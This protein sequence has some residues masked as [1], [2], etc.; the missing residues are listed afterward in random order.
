ME[1][2]VQWKDE[3][4]LE[5]SE[6]YDCCH[7]EALFRKEG[8]EWKLETHGAF[9]TDVWYTCLVKSYPDLDLRVFSQKALQAQNPCE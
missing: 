6:D 2:S 7:V 9:A 3:R 5:I 8:G 4:K 1:G